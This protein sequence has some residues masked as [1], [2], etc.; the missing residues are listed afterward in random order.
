MKKFWRT[1]MQEA[2]NNTTAPN[3]AAHNAP[4]SATAPTT[5][6]T[7]NTTTSSRIVTQFPQGTVEYVRAWRQA[8]NPTPS[9]YSDAEKDRLFKA[10]DNLAR[11][12]CAHYEE[13]DVIVNA[14]IPN[15]DKWTADG[16]SN[17]SNYRDGIINIRGKFSVVTFLSRFARHLGMPGS[18]A[19]LWAK[20]LARQTR[21]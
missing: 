14:D 19:S 8:F 5:G 13:D 4:T 7:T 17:D 2:T 1:K 9:T 6:T 15:A 10:Y 12:L 18:E 16:G 11:I 20:D 21:D 3:A